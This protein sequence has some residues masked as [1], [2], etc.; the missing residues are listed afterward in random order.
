MSSSE[1]KV[2]VVFG[3]TGA[4]GGSVVQAL[5]HD[6]VASQQFHVRA[7][8]RDPSTPASIAL[9]EDG[10]EVVKV[11]SCCYLETL[12]ANSQSLMILFKG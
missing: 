6:L 1:K 11:G 9:I 4:Q 2:V 10:A 3:A 7:I 5:L 12:W 8:T